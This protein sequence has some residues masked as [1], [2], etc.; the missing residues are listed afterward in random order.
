MFKFKKLSKS[1]KILGSLD[2]LILGAKL[3]FIKLK[4]VFFKT[5]IL[6]YFDLER[7]IRIKTDTSGYL[8]SRVFSQLTLDNLG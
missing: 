1:E 4:Q 5:L 2:F 6:H 3:V 7:Y 8:I